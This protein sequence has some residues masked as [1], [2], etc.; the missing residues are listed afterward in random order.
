ME[1]LRREALRLY[2]ELADGPVPFD[3]GPRTLVVV[4]CDAD[5]AAHAARHAAATGG[6]PVEPSDDPWL[7]DDL[8]AAFRIEGSWW[9]DSAAATTA[10]AEAARRAG[11]RF[12]TGCS[13][14]RILAPRGRVAGLA[15]DQGVIACGRIVVAA[16]PRLRFLLRT[17][18]LD[19]PVAALRGWLL[20]TE[21]LTSP[22][23]YALEQAVWPPQEEMGAMAAPP[24]LA[25][26]AAG[27]TAAASLVS[28]LLGA[29]PSNAVLIG[30]SLNRSLAE[31]PEAAETIQAVARR[32]LR[33]VPPLA[34]V[35][36]V[37]T[38]SGRRA[39]TPDGKPVVGPVGAI[40]GLEVAGG[41]WSVGMVTIPAACRDL[42]L[43]RRIPRSLRG[44][45]GLSDVPSP[46]GA[47]AP[48][49]STVIGRDFATL[50]ARS[51]THA[52]TPLAF[53]GQHG[54]GLVQPKPVRATVWRAG[55]SSGRGL[56]VHERRERRPTVRQ[57]YALA[58][59]LCRLHGAEFPMTRGDASDLISRLI[60][61]HVGEP[62]VTR[63][64]AGEPVAPPGDVAPA[65]ATAPG[66]WGPAGD[67]DRDVP[68]YG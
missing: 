32:A 65:R 56:D 27:P 43:G 24:T 1:V 20:E 33:I 44:A 7:A 48:V 8:A 36:V 58:R 39:T 49:P 35:P 47:G 59:L 19:L 13:A 2:T 9:L 10:T 29:R 53:H 67:S 50:P 63:A 21:P 61:D 14:I 6:E 64:R 28:L 11:A 54:N 22:P 51:G 31:E 60:A 18:G 40:E 26:V 68:M 4:A 41:F 52:P 46:G 42:A 5:E 57:V 62:G 15:T 30:T 12:L 38:W 25:E 45:S 17:V 37:A 66:A 16:G 3:F 23:P 55:W 34:G